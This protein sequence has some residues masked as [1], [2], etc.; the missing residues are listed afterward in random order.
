MF[1]EPLWNLRQPIIY[2][3]DNPRDVTILVRWR[4]RKKGIEPLASIISFDLNLAQPFRGL[5][6]LCEFSYLFGAEREAGD[7]HGFVWRLLLPA[8]RRKLAVNVV[9][10]IVKRIK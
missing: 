5:M 1:A 4:A 8:A 3:V 7:N 10:N 2:L 6:D 9:L